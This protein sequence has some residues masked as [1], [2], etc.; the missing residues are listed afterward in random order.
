M[1]K[2]VCLARGLAVV[3]LAFPVRGGLVRGRESPVCFLMK[4]KDVGVLHCW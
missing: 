4:R 2:N 1:A 3:G